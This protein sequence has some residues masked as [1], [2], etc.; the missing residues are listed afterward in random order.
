[1]TQSY[2]NASYTVDDTLWALFAQ[3]N[4]KVRPDLTLDMGLRYEQQTFTDARK[5]FAPRIGFA[6]D[7]RGEGKTVVRG[8]F[9]IYYGQVIDNS[10]ANYALTGPTG[11]FNYTAQP[12]QIGFPTSVSSVPLPAFPAGAVAPVRSL[13]IRPGRAAYY[14]QFFP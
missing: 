1:Y 2:G 9:G 4:W 7:W 5:N 6:Y 14:D 11:F 8:G 3:D 10:Q 13:Y 12:E